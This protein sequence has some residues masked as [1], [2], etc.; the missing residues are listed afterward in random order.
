MVPFLLLEL[1]TAPSVLTGSSSQAWQAQFV[2]H[3][4][5][6]RGRYQETG[7][8]RYASQGHISHCRGRLHVRTAPG[9]NT[10]NTRGGRYARSAPWAG[11]LSR[12][13][14]TAPSARQGTTGMPCRR[15]ARHVQLARLRPSQACP[16]ASHA[17]P[18]TSSRAPMPPS[19]YPAT[20][21]GHRRQGRQHAT[22]AALAATR[23]SRACPCASPACPASTRTTRGRWRAGRAR[24]ATSATGSTR[25]CPTR[26]GRPRSCRAAPRAPRA[27]TRARPAGTSAWTAQ[28][29]P[30]PQPAPSSALR[31]PL[32]P[33]RCRA[34]RTARCARP[35]T[36]RMSR[37]CPSARVAPRGGTTPSTARACASPAPPAPSPTTRRTAAS[38]APR[39]TTLRSTVCRAACAARRARLPTAWSMPRTAKTAQPATSRAQRLP[40]RTS[41]SP[42][43]STPSSRGQATPRACPARLT[44]PGPAGQLPPS[45]RRTSAHPHPQRHPPGRHHLPPAHRTRPS[46]RSPTSRTDLPAAISA[47]CSWVAQSLEVAMLKQDVIWRCTARV[48]CT[49][50]KLY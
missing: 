47:V 17:Q 10:Q 18:A 35:G 37:R 15:T 5:Q 39:A 1:R 33:P 42:A 2:T 14:S 49:L 30:T 27:P 11:C 34:P 24:P 32:A 9:T 6:G 4:L 19:A 25:G 36:T 26:S 16:H 23:T 22:C 12:A 31:A 20:R 13:A 44:C 7:T 38:R 40:S 45:A 28:L 8:A 46:R 48:S 3:A 50:A 41:A 43:P 29:A 21:G